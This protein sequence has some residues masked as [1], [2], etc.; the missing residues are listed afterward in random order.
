MRTPKGA[1]D[2]PTLI[3]M[4]RLVPDP[5]PPRT[6][7]DDELLAFLRSAALEVEAGALRRT[8][9]IGETVLLDADLGGDRVVLLVTR[10]APQHPLSPRELQIVRLV[11]TGHTNRTIARELD[12]SSWTV[13]THLRRIFAKLGVCSRAEMVARVFGTLN[14]PHPRGPL[15][16]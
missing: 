13:S 2:T 4:P 3:P 5:V 7:V 8:D 11:A 14:Q 16:P 10:S 1:V 12:I 6:G 9:D 15:P